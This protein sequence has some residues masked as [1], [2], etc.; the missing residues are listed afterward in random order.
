MTLLS[1]YCY[2]DDPRITK[3]IIGQLH[4]LPHY[5]TPSINAQCQSMP[6]NSDQFLSMSINADTCYGVD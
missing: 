3:F 2:P 1:Y 5:R 6:I 4:R